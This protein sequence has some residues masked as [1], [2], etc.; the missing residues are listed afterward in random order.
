MGLVQYPDPCVLRGECA[1][2]LVVAVVDVVAEEDFT[3]A[4]LG[5]E[6]DEVPFDGVSWRYTACIVLRPESGQ[7]NKKPHRRC[8]RE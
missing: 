1:Q 5:G 6:V 4:A 8:S 2:Q 3:L 7:K